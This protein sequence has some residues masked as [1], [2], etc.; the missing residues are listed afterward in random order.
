MAK[1]V[2]EVFD[3]TDLTE[4]ANDACVPLGTI[5][6]EFNSIIDYDFIDTAPGDLVPL[7]RRIAYVSSDHLGF[8]GF[9]H[10]SQGMDAVMN[11]IY[12]CIAYQDEDALSEFVIPVDA[13]ARKYVYIKIGGS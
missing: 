12:E 11:A 1:A 13:I 2:I 9:Y 8:D 7:N 5:P 4:Y 10:A 3:K 6:L